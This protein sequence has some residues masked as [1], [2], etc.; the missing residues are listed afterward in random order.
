MWKRKCTKD[1]K[2]FA[3]QALSGW[4]LRGVM[5][6]HSI[7]LE[8]GFRLRCTDGGSSR[9]GSREESAYRVR[10]RVAVR[11]PDRGCE[12]DRARACSSCGVHAQM[13]GGRRSER[14]AGG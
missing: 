9:S 7:V 5:G 12:M 6:R 3:T 2:H 10:D 4:L 8:A 13:E 14:C 1:R 11:H